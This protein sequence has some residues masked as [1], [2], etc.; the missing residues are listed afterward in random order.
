MRVLSVLVPV[1]LAACGAAP[2]SPLPS[3]P[4]SAPAS[5]PGAVK[6]PARA[7]AVFK[8]PAFETF[9]L[10]NGLTVYLM[11]HHEVPL[12][13]VS[14]A[15]DAGA[16]RDARGQA[17]L[18]SMT[19]EALLFG[20]GKYS[21]DDFEQISDFHG[22]DL[23]TWIGLEAAGVEA[24]FHKRDADT[25]FPMIDAALTAPRFDAK[26][27]RKY[28]TRLISELAQ[29][30]ESPRAV[31]G[32]YFRRMV[33]GQHPY[34]NTTAGN[35]ES[36]KGLKTKQLKAFHHRH[37][38]P[39]GSAI[40]VVGDFETAKMRARIE[41][42]LGDWKPAAHGAPS[43]LE[44]PKW[45]EAAQVLLIDKPD[46]RETTFLIGGR[47]IRRDDPDYVAIEVI[48]TI[49]GGRFT[50]WLNEALRVDSGLT[51]GARSRFV[52]RRVG[53]SFVISTFTKTATTFEAIAL[54]QK[55]YSRLWEKGIDAGTLASAKAYLKG[56]FPP[57]YETAGQLAE[58][59]TDMHVFAFDAQ[60]I[61]TFQQ[62]IDALTV[63]K[64]AQIITRVFP[65]EHLQFVL[66]GKAEAIRDQ[67]KALGRLL[68]GQ[69]AAP[70]FEAK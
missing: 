24:A 18:A 33:Y 29:A 17:G 12:I 66:I 4:A 63:E 11:E 50:S 23:S 3:A 43:V 64:A 69:I 47:G 56:Q 1:V 61:N 13:H 22:A 2:K 65:K 26:A 10:S 68:E 46:A 5:V 19:A 57:N 40:A 55:T 7:A 21:K 25:F 60:F 70:G 49:L 41:A 52:D 44:A 8:L 30:K 58:L 39:K 48:N 6:A 59:L 14:V 32:N 35:Q 16:V 31:I 38:G 53:G 37:Y 54:A 28:R 42:L 62:Q 36:V 51:Y 15:V 45:P 9:K 20:A 27:V 34:G 67:A